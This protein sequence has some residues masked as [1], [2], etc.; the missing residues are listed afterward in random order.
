M[1]VAVTAMS[2][3][4]ALNS[5]S[6]QSYAE[7]S[8]A[9][10]AYE[11]GDCDTATK[12]FTSLSE[13]GEG[14]SSFVLVTMYESGKCLQRSEENASHMYL[15]AAT[16]GVPKAQ[17]AMAKRYTS[18]TGVSK[19]MPEAIRWLKEAAKHDLEPEAKLLLAAYMLE[20]THLPRDADQIGKLSLF[21]ATQGDP[22]AQF[23]A[24]GAYLEGYNRLPDGTPDVQAALHWL[25]QS[26]QQGHS[27]A[28]AYLGRILLGGRYVKRDVKE[29]QKW[30]CLAAKQDNGNAIQTLNREFLRQQ[31]SARRNSDPDLMI[32]NC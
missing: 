22:F 1:F 16:R 4:L 32:Q 29:A 11:K 25:R 26:A 24:A 21:Q 13:R 27:D 10:S 6:A 23:L 5:A 3:G 9:I 17:F 7:V 15:L 20:G 2:I 31:R 30:L 19:N 14:Y 18:G 12:S 8:A 28:Q